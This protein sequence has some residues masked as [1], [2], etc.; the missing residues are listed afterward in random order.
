MNKLILYLLLVLSYNSFAQ[1]T[2]VSGTIWDANNGQRMPFV[3]VQFKESKI[4]VIS[5]TLG[6][7]SIETYYATDSLVFSFP[8]YLTQIV[9]VNKDEIQEY[10]IRM[11][12]KIN[13]F[14]EV[15]ILPPDEF[16]ST[17]LHK[18]VIAHKDINNKEKLLS[19]EY[20]LYNKIQLDLNNFG[21]K[22]IDQS[23]IKRLD[24]VMDYLDSNDRG[25]N[26]L[27]VILSE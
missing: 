8:G 23:I 10:T 22:S 5:D 25:K 16:P 3:K 21:D 7:F 9:K 17:T 18:K 24:L 12:N 6:Y 4:G 13:E 26:F 27:P 15:K 1:Q 20:E 14:D 2:K 19:Y 11:S